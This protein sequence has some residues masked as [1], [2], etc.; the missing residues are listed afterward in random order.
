[1][2]FNSANLFSVEEARNT[3]AFVVPEFQRG[4]AWNRDQWLALWDDVE[5]TAARPDA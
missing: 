1:M 4:Y 3:Y 2:S 5:G